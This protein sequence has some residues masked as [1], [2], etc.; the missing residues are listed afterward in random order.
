MLVSA[1]CLRVMIGERQ[2]YK[3]MPAQGLEAIDTPA[4]EEVLQFAVAV[5]SLK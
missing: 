1:P 2:C 5:L 4:R 3:H